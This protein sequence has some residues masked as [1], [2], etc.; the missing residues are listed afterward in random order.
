MTA[1]PEELLQDMDVTIIGAGIVGLAVAHHLVE[2]GMQVTIV[3]RDPAGDKASFGNAGG[4]AV[5]EVIPAA[6]PG[7]LWRVPGWLLDPLGPLAVRPAHAP[8]LIPW[9]IR[10]S[11]AGSKAE[12]L[13]I[14]QALAALNLRTYDDL[15]PMLRFHGLSGELH[16]R[17]ALTVYETDAGFRRDQGNWQ[18]RRQLGIEW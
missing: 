15:L 10:F 14:A 16:Q 8:K 12:M 4:I 3:D 2:V 11:R 6:V 5:P 1:A 9:L 7:V 17:G 13:R 18:L